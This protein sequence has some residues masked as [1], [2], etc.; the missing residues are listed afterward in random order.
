VTHG[1][2]NLATEHL[3]YWKTHDISDQYGRLSIYYMCATVP[4]L[5]YTSGVWLAW[6]GLVSDSL[7][8]PAE[9]LAY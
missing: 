5:W 6:T 1:L 8:C 4:S 2:I 3:H 9:I 7:H